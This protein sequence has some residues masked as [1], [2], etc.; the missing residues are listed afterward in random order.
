[1][2]NPKALCLRFSH[3]RGRTSLIVAASGDGEGVKIGW[4]TLVPKARTLVPYVL[5]IRHGY[6]HDPWLKV[7]TC[8]EVW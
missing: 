8:S 5:W 1:M 7:W 4:A 2:E 3:Q 6:M